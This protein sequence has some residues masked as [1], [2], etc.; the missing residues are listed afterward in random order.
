MITGRTHKPH[1]PEDVD[2]K[3]ETIMYKSSWNKSIDE[4]ARLHGNDETDV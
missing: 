3:M 4:E 1:E 2:G